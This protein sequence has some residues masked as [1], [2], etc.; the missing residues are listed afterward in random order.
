[1]AL[2]YAPDWPSLHS[3][4]LSQALDIHANLG[5][6]KDVDW[7]RLVVAYLDNRTSS[8]EGI[9]LLHQD[10]TVGYISALVTNLQGA[11]AT[12]ESSKLH[13]FFVVP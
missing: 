12:L 6:A 11:A 13:A 5:K 10:R 3:F 8:A 1:L 4:A 7:I 9:S 2:N